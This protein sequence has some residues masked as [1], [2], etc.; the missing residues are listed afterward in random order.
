[1]F[2]LRR[3]L[4]DCAGAA[5][6]EFS[7][8]ALPLLILVVGT[9]ELAVGAFIGSTL[10]AAVLEASRYGITGGTVDGVPRAERVRNMIAQKTLGLVDMDEVE[11]ETLVYQSF[12]DI[13][14]PEPFIDVNNDGLYTAG[15]PYTDV[16]GNGQWDADMGAAGLGGPG[17]IVIYNISYEWGIITPFMHKIIGPVLTQSASIAVRNEPF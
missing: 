14:Q 6:L 17:D 15:E 2:R 8:V 16:N 11:L 4:K 1:M 10:E 9:V 7:L 13:G 12:D 3:L 5:A